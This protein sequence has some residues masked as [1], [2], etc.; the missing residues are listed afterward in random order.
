MWR[1]S[2][3]KRFV[4]SDIGR[5]FRSSSFHE[6]ERDRAQRRPE[7]SPV[8][9]DGYGQTQIG[10]TRR[11]N[12]DQFFTVPMDD[13]AVNC[14]LGVAD[15]IGGAPSG[16]E[17][18]HLAAE[19][20]GRFVRE[21]HDRLVRPEESDGEIVQTIIR[22]LQR[23]HNELQDVVNHHP[24]LSGMGTTVTAGLILWPRL[25]VVHMGDARAYLFRDGTLRR[26][27]HDH[28]YAQALLEAGVLNESTLKT[29]TM[30]NVL[31]NYL[32]GDVPEKDP[33]VH[34][35]V[36]IDRLQPGDTLLFCTDG[37]THVMSDEALA[38]VLSSDG[39]PKEL[40]GRLL[41]QARELQARD[42]AT[43]LIARF[44]G[45]PAD[46]SGRRHPRES[47]K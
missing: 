29:S 41:A 40:C 31:S 39:R 4:P 23:C 33:Q 18:S 10:R 37:L 35:D 5:R 19:T 34:P 21:E 12:Q 30:R 43:A 16:E 36:H 20:L 17:A 44:N 22:G 24:E 14:F 9:F 8:Q 28:T 1:R 38:G 25:Y 47:G 15:G 45:P 26:L 11:V 2:D 27:T 46:A 3:S 6:P 32:S 13:S 42:D 7:A